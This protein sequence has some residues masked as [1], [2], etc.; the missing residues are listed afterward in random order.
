[1]TDAKKAAR[2]LI[3]NRL[4]SLI[5]DEDCVRYTAMEVIAAALEAF[6]AERV[7]EERE[8]WAAIGSELH[9][10]AQD[11][12]DSGTLQDG[13]DEIFKE[14]FAAGVACLVSKAIQ[15]PNEARP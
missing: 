1:M 14:G 2:E 3:A 8:R 7:R 15:Q 4:D 5:E 6:A 13:Y 9:R 10:D 12:I 11:A